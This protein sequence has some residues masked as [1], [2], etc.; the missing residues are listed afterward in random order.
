MSLEWLPILL[1]IVKKCFLLYPKL[2]KSKVFYGFQF[3]LCNSR[4]NWLYKNLL[5]FS[6]HINKC[7]DIRPKWDKLIFT[8]MCSFHYFTLLAYKTDGQLLNIL[9]FPFRIYKL[10]SFYWRRIYHPTPELPGLFISGPKGF[11]TGLH[12][13]DGS[14]MKNL[15]SLWRKTWRKSCKNNYNA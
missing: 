9:C 4:Y 6:N 5:L 1:P 11:T 2:H 3:S 14:Q 15:F 7:M 10:F 13:W 12:H 8:S